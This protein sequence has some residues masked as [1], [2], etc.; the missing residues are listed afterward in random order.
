MKDTTI[1]HMKQLAQKELD[2]LMVNHAETGRDRES[3]YPSVEEEEYISYLE[4]VIAGE[5][6]VVEEYHINQ[7]PC[8]GIV[9]EI[10]TQRGNGRELYGR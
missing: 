7:N 3:C 10:D 1:E 2:E 9:A 6:E 4:F 8:A 5:E